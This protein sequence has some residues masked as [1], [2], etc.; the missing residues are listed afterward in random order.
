M[1]YQFAG[2]FASPAVPRPT[3]L[4]S[5]AAWREIASPFVGVGLRL[6]GLVGK[7]PNAQDVEALVRKFG[8]NQAANWIYLSYECWGGQIDFVYGLG[9]SNDKLF[10]P[11]EESSWETAEGAYTAFMKQF[12]V[13]AD[14]ALQFQPFQRGFWGET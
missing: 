3:E 13:S 12:G 5:G 7:P 4:P 9:S 14:A 8:L 6:P 10:G 1:G 11:I 2:F